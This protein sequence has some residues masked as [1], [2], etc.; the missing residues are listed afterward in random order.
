M[1]FFAHQDRARRHTGWLVFLFLLAV[2]G[3]VAAVYVVVLFALGGLA[4]SSGPPPDLWDGGVLLL[5]AVGVLS[6]VGLGSAY[7][8]AQLRAGGP[9]VAALVGARPVLPGTA[10]AAER[11]LL[12]VVE[13]MAIA[14]GVPVPPVFVMDREEGINAFAAGHSTADAAITVTRGTLEQLSRDELQGVVAHEF[15]HILNGDMRLNLR[16]MGTI[17]GILVI[18]MIGWL[19]LRHVRGGKKNPL[20]LIGLA[21]FFVGYAGTFLGN[22]IKA[23]VSRQREFLADAAAVQFTRNPGGLA[24][25]LGKIA[26]TAEGS[27]L[28]AAHAPEVSHMLFGAGTRS[29]L[30]GLLATHPPL[31]ERIRRLGAVVEPAPR[32]PR[33][34]PPAAPARAAAPR[35]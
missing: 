18:G 23:A 28:H 13:E 32:A 14:S 29:A 7:K 12:N 34:A 22:L 10:D 21:L 26:E 17:H 11:R 4:G 16:L 31:A 30:G 35:A 2:A 25:A 6:V 5:T 1:D 19:I 8:T 33:G 15:S 27:R 9:A 3:I 24:G 20:P